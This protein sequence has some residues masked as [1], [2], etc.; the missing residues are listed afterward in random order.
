M[1]MTTRRLLPG[2]GCVVIAVL[3]GVPH[4]VDC[5]DPRRRVRTCFILARVPGAVTAVVMAAVVSVAAAAGS[6]AVTCLTTRAWLQR[7]H[8]RQEA[9]FRRAMTAR[10]CD[11]RAAV[12]SGLCQVTDAFRNS[13]M[14]NAADLRSHLAGALARGWADGIA[15][16][17]GLLLSAAACDQMI[18]L[19][20]ALRRYLSE[21]AD[22]GLPGQLQHGIWPHEGQLRRAVRADPGL[23]LD[24][25]PQA[26]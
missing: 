2:I 19:R 20:Q 6:A 14:D 16:E 22:S 5:L 24:E 12:Y 18:E 3:A 7:G 1:A 26:L 8:D 13:P 21:P 9:E 23:L 4:G 25:G 15:V 11:R 10:L 17:G